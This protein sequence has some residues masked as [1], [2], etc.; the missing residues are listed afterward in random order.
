MPEIK[1][2]PIRPTKV[3]VS[4]EKEYSN[5]IAF[6]EGRE[7]SNIEAINKVRERLANHQRSPKRKQA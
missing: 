2:K 6:A 4:D 7:T 5:F 3:I 1:V